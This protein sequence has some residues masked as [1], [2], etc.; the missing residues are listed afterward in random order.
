MMLRAV[1]TAMVLG[2]LCAGVWAADTGDCV[3]VTMFSGIEHKDS[4]QKVDAETVVVRPAFCEK[5]LRRTDIIST[6]KDLPEEEKVALRAAVLE[7]ENERGAALKRLA[8]PADE[9]P[10]AGIRVPREAL[11]NGARQAFGARIEP[12][13]DPYERMSRQ[14]DKRISVEFVDTP[15]EDA[16]QFMATLTG[17]NFILS[18]KVREAKPVLSLRVRDMDAGTVVKWLTKLTETYAEVKDQAIF[19]TDKPSPEAANEERDEILMLAASLGATVDLP[20][21]GQPLTPQDRT[22][23]A[24]QLWEK[25][26]PKLQDFPGPDVGL[27]GTLDAANPFGAGPRP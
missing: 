15:L 1:V 17:A 7:S 2:V 9:A 8:A 10:R 6:R 18:A 4:L 19:I 22:K 23:I 26:Q 16:I 20:P 21:E 11:D 5:T 3:R 14:L 24:L 25:E 27:A 12:H 13:L